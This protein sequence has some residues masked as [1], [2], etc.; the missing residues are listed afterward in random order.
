MTATFYKIENGQ[1]VHAD[2]DAEW[3]EIADHRDRLVAKLYRINGEP[4]A[5]QLRLRVTRV[6]TALAE[7][8]SK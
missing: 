1:I 7:P 3:A 5:E 8:S 2:G 6:L 4:D